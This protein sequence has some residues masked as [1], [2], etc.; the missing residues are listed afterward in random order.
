MFYMEIRAQNRDFVTFFGE[1]TV[2]LVACLCI[3]LSVLVVEV[4]RGFLAM[5]I[6][7]GGASAWP[8]SPQLGLAGELS[9]LATDGGLRDQGF[10]YRLQML[11]R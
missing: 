7:W 11:I 9:E 1:L 8:F 4:A 6:V 10:A 2:L 3:Y 5:R